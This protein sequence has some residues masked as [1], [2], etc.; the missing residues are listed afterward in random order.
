[1]AFFPIQPYPTLGLA[2]FGGV[3]QACYA[4]FF[5]IRESDETSNDD[6]V[7]RF[8]VVLLELDAA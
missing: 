8:C 3:I 2:L 4:L 5:C 1:M 7:K 6:P